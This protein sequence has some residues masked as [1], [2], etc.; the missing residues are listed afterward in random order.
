MTLDARHLSQVM[1][2]FWAADPGDAGEGTVSLP[3]LCPSPSLACLLDGSGGKGTFQIVTLWRPVFHTFSGLA[4][5]V[6]LA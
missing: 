6:S 3:S 1:S 4:F 5:H 2:S